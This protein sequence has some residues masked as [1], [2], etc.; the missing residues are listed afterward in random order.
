MYK[1]CASETRFWSAQAML[2]LWKPVAMLQAA[3]GRSTASPSKG[4][5]VAPALQRAI[6]RVLDMNQIGH[7]HD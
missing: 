4:G 1:I 2:A 3:N 6:A 5:S 7:L